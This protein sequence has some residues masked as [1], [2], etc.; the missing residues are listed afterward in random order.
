MIAINEQ[1][2]VTVAGNGHHP[3]Y[4]LHE[5]AMVLPEMDE[6]TFSSLK[7]SII[8]HGQR[9]PIIL[10]REPVIDGRHRLKACRELQ[11]TPVVRRLPDDVDPYAFVEDTNLVRRSLAEGQRVL[12]PVYK[13][14]DGDRWLY[15]VPS[16]SFGI[17]PIPPFG[18][19]NH[20]P[21]SILSADANTEAEVC[22]LP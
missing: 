6:E 2:P 1:M 15:L 8:A 3:D 10:W 17:G 16:R 20:K 4:E 9:E 21:G 18:L 13:L 14:R 5:L 19:Q 11:V 22:L 7:E 12:G